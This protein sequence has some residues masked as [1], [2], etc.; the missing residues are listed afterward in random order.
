MP[1]TRASRTRAHKMHVIT[2]VTLAVCD[3]L[4]VPNTLSLSLS[5]ARA[6]LL[7]FL[8]NHFSLTLSISLSSLFSLLSSLFSLLASRFSLLASLSRALSPLAKGARDT[9]RRKDGSDT[10]RRK[11]R[12]GKS[13]AHTPIAVTPSRKGKAYEKVLCVSPACLPVS[14]S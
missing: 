9:F 13:E 3:C 11:V 12:E 2:L 4:L 6:L 1:V 5:C 14:R 8:L 7:S 10:F